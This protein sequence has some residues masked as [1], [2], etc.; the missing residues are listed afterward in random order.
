M[1]EVTDTGSTLES[2]TAKDFDVSVDA[3][4]LRSGSHSL[5]GTVNSEKKLHKATL[6]N[7]NINIYLSKKD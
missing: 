4:G 3:K 7:E 2:L 5:K 1:V 6:E